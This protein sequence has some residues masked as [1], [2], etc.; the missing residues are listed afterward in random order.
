MAF[1]AKKTHAP[2]SYLQLFYNGGYM[3]GYILTENEYMATVEFRALK[4][5][6]K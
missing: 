1:H 4:G 6:K 5:P 2:L 3:S